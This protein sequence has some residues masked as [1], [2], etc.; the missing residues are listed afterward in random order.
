MKRRQKAQAGRPERFGQ[1]A[2]RSV[3]FTPASLKDDEPGVP[4][5]SAGD[6]QCGRSNRSDE[7]EPLS[8][9][10]LSAKYGLGFSILRSM[11]YSGAGLKPGSLQAPL[12]ARANAGRQGLAEAAETAETAEDGGVPTRQ[13]PDEPAVDLTRLLSQTLRSM[14]EAGDDE[15]ASELEHMA[16]FC[17]LQGEALEALQPK[18]PKRKR[19][20]QE[21]S[22]DRAAEEAAV[23][24]V[25]GCFEEADFPVEMQE[26]ARALKWKKRW[27]TSLGSFEEFV[28]RHGPE[29]RAIECPG[30]VSLLL[31]RHPL[32]NE[33][34]LQR[35][36]FD[37]CQARA[38][39]VGKCQGRRKWQH[40]IKTLRLVFRGRASKSIGKELEPLGSPVVLFSL[41][42]GSR[43][44]C[45][46][47]KWPTPIKGALI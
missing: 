5:P 47:K 9:E 10:E 12:A 24:C 46:V 23:K 14:R 43:F 18:R 32:P 31:P 6:A 30:G 44:S 38:R 7:L 39:S 15:E 37:F 22:L 13:E 41:F 25:L 28:A 3:P 20:I 1:Q 36:C 26:Q 34:L 4:G 11:G 35:K 40:I 17:N 2:L 8:H 45:K 19:Q 27:A 21:V 29:L 16:T 42:F 33:D